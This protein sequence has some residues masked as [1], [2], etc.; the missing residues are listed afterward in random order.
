M[1]DHGFGG[2]VCGSVV[3][4][5]LFARECVTMLQDVSATNDGAMVTVPSENML[6]GAKGRRR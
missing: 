6:R 4:R 2:T 5:R 3:D 1:N